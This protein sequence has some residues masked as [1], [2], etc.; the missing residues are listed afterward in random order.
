M[1]YESGHPAECGSALN[2]LIYPFQGACSPEIAAVSNKSVIEA[3]MVN[4]VNSGSNTVGRCSDLATNKH[5]ADYRSTSVQQPPKKAGPSQRG[6]RLV[7][8]NSASRSICTQHQK[9]EL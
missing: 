1:R 2:S 3:C 5:I 8:G 7:C 4:E 9:R 6:K